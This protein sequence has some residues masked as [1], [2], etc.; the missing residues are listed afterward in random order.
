MNHGL[1]ISFLVGLFWAI[2]V[3][4]EKHYLLKYFKSHE[5]VYMRGPF[6]LLFFIFYTFI[7]NRKFSKKLINISKISLF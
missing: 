1:F 3:V 5:L 7:Y 2:T 6:I 4:F